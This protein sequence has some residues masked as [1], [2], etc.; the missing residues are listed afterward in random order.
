MDF[1]DGADDDDA[2]AAIDVDSVVRGARAA[3]DASASAAT[4]AARV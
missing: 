3:R 2:F 4:R 1:D